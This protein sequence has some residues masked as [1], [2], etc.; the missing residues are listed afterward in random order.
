MWG[1]ATANV[2]PDEALVQAMSAEAVSKTKDF[3][4]QEIA[5][6]MWALAKLDVTL[7]AV[8]VQVMSAEAIS[9]SKDFDP[10]AIANLMW[11]LTKFGVSPDAAL[12]RATLDNI[13]VGDLDPKHNAQLHQFFVFN[14]LSAHPVDVSSWAD[15][16]AK[17]KKA[18]P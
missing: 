15:L 18:N 5:N 9:K 14:S 16:V 17:C 8:L 7:D 10:Q 6:L 2:P 13:S 11:A 3:K 1:L 12:L 4:P